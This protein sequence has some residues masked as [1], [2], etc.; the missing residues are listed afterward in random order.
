MHWTGTK[1]VEGPILWKALG[2]VSDLHRQV[3]HQ[4]VIG[5]AQHTVTDEDEVRIYPRHQQCQLVQ[6]GQG[7]IGGPKNPAPRRGGLHLSGK[8][9]RKTSLKSRAVHALGHPDTQ[10]PTFPGADQTRKLHLGLAKGGGDHIAEAGDLGPDH[11]MAGGSEALR[12]REGRRRP[13]PG[14]S[15]HSPDRARLAK[16]LPRKNTREVNPSA[17]KIPLHGQGPDRRKGRRRRRCT[18]E[19]REGSTGKR[20]G[21]TASARTL[22]QVHLE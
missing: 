8:I 21:V 9:L 19:V 20:L 12:Q 3:G 18:H 7:H 16:K 2:E 11:P 13:K 14:T 10:L 15:K 1:A 5:G 17:E 6:H 4:G 22:H